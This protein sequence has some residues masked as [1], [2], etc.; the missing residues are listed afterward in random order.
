M[1]IKNIAQLK[2]A[3]ARKE[4]IQRELEEYDKIPD[5]QNE[6]Y[7]TPLLIELRGLDEGIDEFNKLTAFPF[8]MAVEDVLNKPI[9]IDN[10]SEL[11]AKLRIAAKLTQE[12]MAERLGWDQPNLSRFENENYNSQTLSKIIEY[13]SNLGIW[14]HISPSLTE[15]PIV[16]ASEAFLRLSTFQFNNSND[17][18]PLPDRLYLKTTFNTNPSSTSSYSPILDNAEG[19][20]YR[21][22]ALSSE[23]IGV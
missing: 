9:L 7:T 12:E 18:M 6:F 3:L 11:L 10:I 13:A 16:I 4:T 19:N 5:I 14:L 17:I 23:L 1:I 8:E 22:F 2:S 21:D 20:R 15:E